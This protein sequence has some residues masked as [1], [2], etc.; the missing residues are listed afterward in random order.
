M[1]QKLKRLGSYFRWLGLVVFLAGVLLALFEV[2][3]GITVIAL[4]IL[5]ALQGSIIEFIFR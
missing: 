5:A 1:E 4:G 2:S 3:G